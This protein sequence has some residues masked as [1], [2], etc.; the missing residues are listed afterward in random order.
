MSLEYGIHVI[1][2]ICKQTHS[3]T[4]QQNFIDSVANYFPRIEVFIF[5]V[6]IIDFFLL[7]M[8]LKTMYM[9]SKQ[10]LM[11][12]YR[13]SLIMIYYCPAVVVLEN[14]LIYCLISLGV[15]SA[16]FHPI[17]YSY[18]SRRFIISAAGN[19]DCVR[20]YP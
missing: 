19:G 14:G 15:P 20:I 17:Y 1:T 13:L 9:F 6:S 2:N 16:Q 3:Q 5:P 18:V 12:V 4:A 10:N 7:E 11:Q 8:M